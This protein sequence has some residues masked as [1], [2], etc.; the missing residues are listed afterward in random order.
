MLDSLFQTG[1]CGTLEVPSGFFRGA[2]A[3]CLKIALKCFYLQVYKIINRFLLHKASVFYCATLKTWAPCRPAASILS[4][5]IDGEG[6]SGTLAVDVLVCTSHAS[7][8]QFS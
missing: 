6:E 5:I 8:C 2:I 3:K 7:L 1:C 4:D